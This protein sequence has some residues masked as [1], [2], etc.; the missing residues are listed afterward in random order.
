MFAIK[1]VSNETFGKSDPFVGEC[2]EQSHR[3]EATFSALF[4][5]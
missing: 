2:I 5:P 1:P 4:S 3:Y